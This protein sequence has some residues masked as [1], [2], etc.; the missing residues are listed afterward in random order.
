MRFKKTK[1]EALQDIIND[2]MDVNGNGPVDMKVIAAWAIA[3]DRWEPKPIS[4]VR[5]AA[6]ELSAA[7]REENYRDPQGRLVRKK[8]VVRE[9]TSE[10]EQ[11]YLWAD[12]EDANPEHMR[13]SLSQRRRGILGDCRRLKTDLDSYNENN[14]HGG[15]VQLDFD[16]TCDLEEMDQPTDYPD[17]PSEE[18]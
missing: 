16:F 7:A 9:A 3:T 1:A 4:L 15:Q 18:E 10:G 2:Y 11:R 13:R 5:M 17:S 8:H 6:A 12:I 14:I